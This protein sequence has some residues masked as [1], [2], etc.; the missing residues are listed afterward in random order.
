MRDG[1]SRLV[2]K[3]NEKRFNY[4]K[5]ATGLGS[6]VGSTDLD[7][8]PLSGSDVGLEPLTGSGVGLEVLA[9]EHVSLDTACK[10]GGFRY[11]GFAH[12]GRSCGITVRHRE[13][14]LTGRLENSFYS[15][16]DVGLTQKPLKFYNRKS[17]AKRD[18]KMDVGL[19][20]ETL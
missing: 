19:L 18:S 4:A 15:L 7:P 20:A 6:L 8:R 5:S 10:T 1:P 12:L 9:N 14:M 2:F 13:A 16:A 3:P 11:D 17:K